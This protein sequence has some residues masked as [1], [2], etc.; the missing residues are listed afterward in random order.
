LT[1]SPF[2]VGAQTQYKVA[3]MA[4]APAAYGWVEP[5]D[6]G[7]T[8]N[9]SGSAGNNTFNGWLLFTTNA[10]S[11]AQNWYNPDIAAYNISSGEF[12]I[13]TSTGALS[14]MWNEHGAIT[15]DG[16]QLV[17][18]T[19]Q[20]NPTWLDSPTN[21][22]SPIDYWLANVQSANGNLQLSAPRRLTYRNVAGNPETDLSQTGPNIG[23]GNGKCE[24]FPGAR[25]YNLLTLLLH[26]N[27][28]FA[29]GE[30][31]FASVG[32]SISGN[33]KITGS[34]TLR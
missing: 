24:F 9:L 31:Q 11:V 14:G 4:G 17:F 29:N 8:F 21:T 1:Y 15:P 32:Q 10:T 12:S 7:G 18:A 25:P 26:P 22:F 28:E 23:T 6:A 27:S 13:L 34:V 5:I 20:N 2:T 33:A 16:S 30:L 19:T 3:N